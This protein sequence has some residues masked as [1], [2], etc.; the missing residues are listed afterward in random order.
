MTT[1]IELTYDRLLSGGIP[2]KKEDVITFIADL[3]NNA[4]TDQRT[5]KMVAVVT[6]SSAHARYIKKEL[7][8]HMDV[9]AGVDI[10]P[11]MDL[12]LSHSIERAATPPVKKIAIIDTLKTR[13]DD[14]ILPFHYERSARD[15]LIDT[16][17]ALIR[18]R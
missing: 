10:A 18:V 6:T 11:V 16:A 2:I 15:H 13:L 4:R 3:I 5:S 17:S 9:L 7:S 14:G 12:F 1:G 8:R